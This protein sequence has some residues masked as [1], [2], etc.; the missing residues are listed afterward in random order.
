[1]I[2]KNVNNKTHIEAPIHSWPTGYCKIQTEAYVVETCFLGHRFTTLL[3]INYRREKLYQ[4]F[5]SLQVC[6]FQLLEIFPNNIF[7]LLSD[8]F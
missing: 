2:T 7:L 5:G 6:F 8:C 3:E 4:K 1:M